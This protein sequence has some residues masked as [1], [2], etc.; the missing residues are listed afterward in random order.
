MN[1]KPLRTISEYDV[2][3]F[4][5]FNG[6]SANRGTFVSAVGSGINFK[7]DEVVLDNLS[8]VDNTISA[9]FNVP[10]L[11]QPAPS[12]SL[13]SAVLGFLQKDHRTVDENGY[14]LIYEP[15]KA[16]EMDVTVSGQATPIVTRGLVL[17]SGI[18]GTPSVGDGA[19]V[20]DA[21]DGS[22][23]VVSQ[24]VSV[25]GVSSPNPAVVGKFLGPKNSEGY[26]LLLVNL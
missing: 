6:A 10:W 20:A 19:A 3:P 14:P 7:D 18:V 26:A 16:A 9:Q 12:G 21:G 15:R 22:L 25:S 17:Y 11:C 2:I 8:Y 1:I 13:A 4:F 5:S 24:T 23:K